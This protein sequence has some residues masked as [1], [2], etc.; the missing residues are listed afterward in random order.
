[1]ALAGDIIYAA[2]INSLLTGPANVVQWVDG[3]PAVADS[4]TWNATESAA[5][6][7][8]TVPL[9]AGRTYRVDLACHVSTDTQTFALSQANAETAVIRIREDTATGTQMIGDHIPIYHNGTLG[10]KLTTYAW[11]TAVAT[12]NKTFVVTGQ[13]GANGSGGLQRFRA[14]ATRP[15]LL[16]VYQVKG[17]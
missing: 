4:A 16:S 5:L 12:G 15:G 7:S 1:M 10:F 14:G 9:V 17:A 3:V 2:D 8:I 13:H 11:Y 6:M